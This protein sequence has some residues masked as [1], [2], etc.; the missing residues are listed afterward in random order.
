M[1]I[2]E[3]LESVDKE[4]L[5]EDT[6]NKIQSLVEAK[7]AEKAEIIKESALLEQDE[8]HTKK[9]HQLVKLIDEDHSKKL[10]STIEKIEEKYK[11]K[12]GQI[13]ENY[14]S[15]TGK[16]AK[17]HI[18]QLTED[19]DKFLD[20]YVEELVPVQLVEEAAKNTY[21]SR[22]LNEAKSVLSVNEKFANKKFRSAV[23]D[24]YDKIENLTEELN[25][26]N[27]ELDRVRSKTFLESRTQS[28][29]KAK[30]NFIKKRLDG[31]PL[32]FIK[33][34]FKFVESLYTEKDSSPLLNKSTPRPSVD[35][36]IVENTILTEETN[37]DS[38]L[39]SEDSDPTMDFY[40]EGLMEPR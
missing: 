17:K 25:R 5:N 19:I 16:Q 28:M 22:L 23:Q 35:R 10:S 24:G 40:M 18:K 14:E 36:Q 21:A 31:K 7:A 30:A 4:I 37:A 32:S 11:E 9:L 39:I 12:L 33:E 20:L 27:K 34:Q 6:L 8:L 2:S 29:P 13:V 15:E 3:V 26:K 1:D 38:E